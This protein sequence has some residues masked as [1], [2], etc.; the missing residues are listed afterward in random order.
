MNIKFF[1]CCTTVLFIQAIN[2][3]NSQ[4]FGLFPTIDHSGTISDKFDYSLYYFGA[5]NLSNSEINGVKED[6]NFTAFYAEQALTY[7]V[8]SKISFTGS[9]VYERQRPLNDNYRNENRFYLQSTFKHNLG[10]FKVKHRLRYDGRFIENKLT[11][12]S[13]F[14]SRARYLIGATIPL[15]KEND[16]FY[17]SLYNEF[18]FNL[19]KNAEVVYDE[20]W[21]N[22]SLGYKLNSNNSFEVG[23]L[24]IS[25]ITNK[26]R[27]I[28]N[29]DYLQLTWINHLD[30]RKKK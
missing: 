6:A 8:N 7:N 17:L 18:F 27:D 30:F 9:Y 3:Q 25:G 15:N 10:K 20:N 21:A 26:E 11:N 14:T 24:N 2:A 1:I 12:K 16:K 13:P 19:N 23:L 5:F 22:A 4:S 29:F 28:S